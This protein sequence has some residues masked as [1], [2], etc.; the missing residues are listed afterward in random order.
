MRALRL[1]MTTAMFSLALS[2]VCS[3]QYGACRTVFDFE[4]AADL[5]S[6]V[7]QCH[8]WFQLSDRHATKGKKSLK[9]ELYPPAEYPGLKFVGLKGQ[10]KGARYLLLDIFNPTGKD[11]TMTIRIDDRPG[12]PPY[13]DRVNHRVV[14]K[15]GQNTVVLDLAKLRTSGTDRALEPKNVH[16]FLLFANRPKGPITIFVDNI[17]LCKGK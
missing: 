15:P 8:T 2:G 3:G 7:Y 11:L 5:S 13:E 14:L 12:H 9:V 16:R 4:T 1:L 6:L 10:W 17:R